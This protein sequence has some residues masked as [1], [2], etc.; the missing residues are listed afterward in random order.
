MIQYIDP[1]IRPS[2]RIKFPYMKLHGFTIEKRLTASG[3]FLAQITIVPKWAAAWH[4]KRY[5]DLDAAVRMISGIAQE[6]TVQ[7]QMSA[8]VELMAIGIIPY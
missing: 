6:R 7:K 4:G 2:S 5:I 3:K 1:A 8:D